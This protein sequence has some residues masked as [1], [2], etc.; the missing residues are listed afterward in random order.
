MAKKKETKESIL[1]RISDLKECEQTPEVMQEIDELQAKADAMPDEP[2]KGTSHTV[3]LDISPKG[4]TPNY[5]HEEWKLERKVENGKVVFN[6]DKLL[7]KVI[8]LPEHAR[9][10]NFQMENTLKEYVE[11]NKEA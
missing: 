2:V 10:L 11:I 1:K 8:L 9:D 7:K 6:R 4:K 3:G 5:T